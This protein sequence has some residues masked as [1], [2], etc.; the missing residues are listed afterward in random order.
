MP[1]LAGGGAERVMLNLAA[2]FARRGFHPDLV[3]AAAEG[4]LS[5]AVPAGVR[6]IDLK[7]SRTLRALPGLAAYLR[8]ERPVS[9]LSA[10]DHAN[11]VALAAARTPRARTRTIISIHCTRAAEVDDGF[12][13]RDRS[14][15]VLLGFAHRWADGIVAVS[16]GVAEDASE[17]IGIPRERIEVIYNPVIGPELFQS[18]AEPPRHAWFEDA[19]SPVVLGVGRLSPQKNF[20]ALIEAFSRVRRQHEARLVILGEGSERVALEALV[21]RL[22][23][24][25]CVSLP[26][27]LDNPYACMARAAVFVLSSNWEGLPTAL[28]E[29]LALGTPVV[30]TDCPSGPRE[31]LREGAL[32][33]LV[34]TGDTNSLAEA[35][36]VALATRRADAPAEA[37]RPFMSNVVLD[38]YE[39]VLGLA[40]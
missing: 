27:F 29:S 15:P 38:Q 28:I 3:L 34:P 2:G 25:D 18:A 37:L 16:D 6:V 7:V 14:I 17:T 23:M 22:G 40:A 1:S 30:S 10:L 8:R 20:P 36:E 31:I 19:G 13:L 12:D 5:N 4:S 24:T 11:L 33:R 26:G 35:I 21:R 32:G 9:L 39:R